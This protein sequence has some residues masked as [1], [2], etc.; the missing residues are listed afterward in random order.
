MKFPRTF[1]AA[2]AACLVAAGPAAAMMM[3]GGQAATPPRHAVVTPR[4]AAP[5]TL[6]LIAGVISA[7]D[8]PKKTL[9]ISGNT[10]AWHPTHLRVF[11]QG[12]VRA[13]EH[14]LRAGMRVRFAL[15]P[16]TAVAANAARRAV[17]I[18]VDEG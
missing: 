12:G 11:M 16:A 18:F 17:V 14:D 6:D 1:A 9:T 8:L 4:T 7:V 3:D 2:A 10:L 15:E 5:A 13:G